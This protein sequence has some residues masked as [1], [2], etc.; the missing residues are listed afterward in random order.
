METTGENA[1]GSQVLRHAARET[2]WEPAVDGDE[3]TARAIEAHIERYFGPIAFV[4]HEIV[5]D[6]VH[7]DVHVVEPTPQRPYFVLVT[8]G[9]SDRPMNVPAAAEVSPFAEL[10]LCLPETW[11]LNADAFEDENAYWPI[12][13]LK[14]VARLPHEYNTW[15]GEWHSVPNG[16]PAEPFASKTPFAGVLVAPM[17]RC[18]PEA[19]TIVTESGKEISL[20]ALVPLH[21]AEID[22]KVARGTDALLDAFDAISVSEIFDPARPSAV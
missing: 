3:E 19:N 15:I 9:M 8:S 2:S 6:L 13:W 16:D 18:E 10:M 14:M 17:V 12:R 21:R 5:S 4:W 1:A 20:L 22:L 7:I 11:P